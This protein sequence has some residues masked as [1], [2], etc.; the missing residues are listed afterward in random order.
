VIA[1]VLAIALALQFG[2]LAMVR[3]PVDAGLNHAAAI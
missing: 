3:S 1:V 2:R